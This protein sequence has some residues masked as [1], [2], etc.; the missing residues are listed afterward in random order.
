MKEVSLS[1]IKNDPSR[2]LREV[3]HDPRFLRRVE[4]SRNSLRGARCEA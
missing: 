2:N 1:E 4:Q 3:E